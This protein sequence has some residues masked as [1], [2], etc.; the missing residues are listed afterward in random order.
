MFSSTNVWCCLD[1]LCWRGALDAII[2]AAHVN[3]GSRNRGPSR[4]RHRGRYNHRTHHRPNNRNRDHRGTYHRRNNHGVG[5]LARGSADHFTVT[6]CQLHANG[7][8][9]RLR[10]A[11]FAMTGNVIYA[12][13]NASSS[14]ST[15]SSS[16]S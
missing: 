6:G 1:G 4:S 7:Q 13:A 5:V 16:S 3:G 8:A 9:V 14:S 10:S 12:N 2:S 15:S 11:S